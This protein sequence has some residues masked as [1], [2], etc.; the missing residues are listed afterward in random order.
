MTNEVFAIELS[1][2]MAGCLGYLP[3]RTIPRNEENNPFSSV[4]FERCSAHGVIPTE[5]FPY[6]DARAGA[7]GYRPRGQRTTLAFAS[8]LS[9]RIKQSIK[10][11]LFTSQFELD[12]AHSVYI[13][14]SPT[15]ASIIS[16]SAP[17]THFS[18]RCTQIAILCVLGL[19][20]KSK[21]VLTVAFGRDATN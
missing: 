18:S 19:R 6:F 10:V 16:H 9:T 21:G 3:E 12:S 7:H 2:D 15:P 1:P 11:C 13:F 17:M 14:P 20:Y 8:V 4:M 5:T